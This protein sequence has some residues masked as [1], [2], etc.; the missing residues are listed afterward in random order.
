MDTSTCSQLKSQLSTRGT[1]VSSSCNNT[2][3][4]S[5][6]IVFTPRTLA[7]VVAIGSQ[8]IT[9]GTADSGATNLVQPVDQSGSANVAI[10]NLAT[11]SSSSMT[12][13]TLSSTPSTSS[14]INGSSGTVVSGGS[15]TTPSAAR[16]PVWQGSATMSCRYRLTTR[17]IAWSIASELASL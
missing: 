15:T 11:G 10:S 4:Q 5:N 8:V 6:K 14:M 3:P 12:A 17:R 16:P 7:T 1:I 9:V 13:G 2:N